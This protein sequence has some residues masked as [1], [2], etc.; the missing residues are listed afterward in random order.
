MTVAPVA[1]ALAD[2]IGERPLMVTGLSLQAAGMAWLAAIA[3]PG[4]AYS[5]LL[6]PFILAGAVSRWRSRRRRTP[7]SGSLAIDALG[8]VVGANSMIRELGGVFGIA[9]AVAVFR[10]RRQLRVSGHVHRRLQSGDRRRGRPG[11]ARSGRRPG[12]PRPAPEHGSGTGRGP[13]ADDGLNPLASPARARR[14]ARPG[15][16]GRQCARSSARSFLAVSRAAWSL[17]GVGRR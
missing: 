1:G 6:A 10:R 9:L 12:A 13:G 7:S 15:A 3:E 2:R 16:G 14:R 8:K 11:A 17:A 5:E 4:I